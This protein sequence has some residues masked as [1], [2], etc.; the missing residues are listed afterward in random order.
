V[1]KEYVKTL[2]KTRCRS[3]IYILAGLMP[4]I[5]FIP[6]AILTWPYSGTGTILTDWTRTLILKICQF[7]GK[8]RNGAAGR[9]RYEAGVGVDYLGMRTFD[10]NDSGNLPAYAI[11]GNATGNQSFIASAGASASLPFQAF[12]VAWRASAAANVG[13]E[14]AG[15]SVSLNVGLLNSTIEIQSGKIGRTRVN[16]GAGLAGYVAERTKMAVALSNQSADNWN[17]TSLT[18]SISMEF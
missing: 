11:K 17:A 6:T 10:F 14:C 18:A 12:G 3:G 1:N 8:W 4:K 16:V 15:N 2:E 5:P 9:V 7:T 13:Y